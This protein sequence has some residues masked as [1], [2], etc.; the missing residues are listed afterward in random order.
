MAVSGT[1][2]WFSNVK[3]FG[4][5]E[6][7]GKDVFVHYSAIQGDKYKTL[8][9]GDKVT[10]DLVESEKGPQASNVVREQKPKAEKS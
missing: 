4:F 7:E 1:V 6:H 3:G 9:G 10:F 8:E 2:K 5:I